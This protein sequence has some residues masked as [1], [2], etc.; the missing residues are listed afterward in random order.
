MNEKFGND[1]DFNFDFNN[2]DPA[3]LQTDDTINAVF[4]LDKSPSMMERLPGAK[5]GEPQTRIEA[6]NA[7]LNDFTQTMQKSH[8]ADRLLVSVVVFDD[9][10]EVL[11]GY[12]PIVNV[13]PFNITPERGMTALYKACLIGITNAVNYRK[14]LEDSGITAKTLVFIITDGEDNQSPMDAPKVKSLLEQINKDEKNVFSFT[15]ILFGIGEDSNIEKSREVMG[16]AKELV[17]PPATTGAEFRKMINW[18]SSSVSSAATN[19]S[20]PSF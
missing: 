11:S 1:V 12:Q 18:I 19:Q 9:K 3:S 8:I 13:K 7:G 4:I 6:L 10:V 5:P 17:A 20:I 16:I 15:T 14:N 2:V